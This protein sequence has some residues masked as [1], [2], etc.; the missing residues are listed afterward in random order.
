MKKILC[1]LSIVIAAAAVFAKP[2]LMAIATFDINNNAVSEAEAEGI[3]ELYIAELASTGKVSIVDR[4]NFNKLLKEMNF[5]AGD[6]AD[7]EKTIRLGT[8]S[9]ASVIGRGQIIKLGN[10][11]YLSATVIDVKTA[12]VISSAKTQFDSLDD[13]FNIL[14]GFVRD[15]SEGLTLKIGDT[16]PGGGL[17][18]NIEG[19]RGLECSEVLGSASWENA[20]K[21]C[22][23]FR[24]GG[25]DDW[26]L[27][28]KEELNFIY[29][30]LARTGEITAHGE[31]WS[32][33]YYGLYND[34]WDGKSYYAAYYQ[35]F[36]DGSIYMYSSIEDLKSVRA[37][38]AFNIDD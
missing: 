7:S 2:K 9:G 30:N 28:S 37:V 12:K 25:Y 8:A 6:W 14:P 1:A 3:T 11:M 4:N 23:E 27:P 5:Q 18:C 10:K 29:R 16:G 21:M 24:G 35:F 31:F 33:T 13:I 36:N 38:R 17:I 26:Y 19:N 22:A 32:S 15:I 20:K 34:T